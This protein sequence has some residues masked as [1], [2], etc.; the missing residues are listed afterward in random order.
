M[1]KVPQYTRQRVWGSARC[2]LIRTIRR[3]QES[4][5]AVGLGGEENAQT[6]DV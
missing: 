1:S 4:A 2:R 3:A 5:I 6:S